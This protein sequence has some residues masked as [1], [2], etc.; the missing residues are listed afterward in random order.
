[1]WMSFGTLKENIVYIN[2]I[3]FYFIYFLH[4]Y[5]FLP[6]LHKSRQTNSAITLICFFATDL[7]KCHF[8]FS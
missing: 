3:I 2:F 1:M 5:A 7:K 4:I 8:K 6:T